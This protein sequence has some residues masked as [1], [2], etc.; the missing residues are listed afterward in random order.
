VLGERRSEEVVEN[1]SH[2][3]EKVNFSIEHL[4]ISQEVEFLKKLRLKR[5]IEGLTKRQK[6]C[7]YL[8][9]FQGLDNLAIASVMGLS[10][11]SV[12]TLV[13]QALSS[14]RAKVG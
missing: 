13:S 12:N 4:M 5:A 6:E 3:E 9:F 7:V 14:L 1:A 11:S 8:K 10:E 2:Q